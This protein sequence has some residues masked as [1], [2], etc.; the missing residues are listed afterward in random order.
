MFIINVVYSIQNDENIFVAKND[1]MCTVGANK[2]L[3]AGTF[4][5]APSRLRANGVRSGMKR[6]CYP[7]HSE[8]FQSDHARN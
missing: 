4:S 7:T 1:R 6:I 2:K 5:R 3:K 8:T